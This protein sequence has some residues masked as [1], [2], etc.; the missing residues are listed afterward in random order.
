MTMN[1]IRYILNAI[2]KITS[3][4]AFEE[5]DSG[6]EVYWTVENELFEYGCCYM[7]EE[8]GSIFYSYDLQTVTPINHIDDVISSVWYM[9]EYNTEEDTTLDFNIFEANLNDLLLPQ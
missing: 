4:F 2:T 9:K 6:F 7:F 3:E 8:N 5:T 1:H